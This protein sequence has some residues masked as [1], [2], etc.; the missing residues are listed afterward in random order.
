MNPARL[1]H[2]GEE[3]IRRVPKRALIDNREIVAAM[4]KELSQPSP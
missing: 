1:L 4:L 2:S 3:S